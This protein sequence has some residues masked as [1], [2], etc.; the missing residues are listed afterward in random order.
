MSIN[1]PPLSRLRCQGIRDGK[2][3]SATEPV[4]GT[5]RHPWRCAAC[6]VPLYDGLTAEQ[7][8][9]RY[10]K[11]QRGEAERWAIKWRQGYFR[12]HEAAVYAVKFCAGTGMTYIVVPL[13]LAACQLAAACDLWSV[14]LKAKVQAS[15]K[16]KLTIMVDYED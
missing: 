14:Q 12:D 1:G 15:T 13:R 9:E 6:S 11:I 16:P 8:L 4:D 7:C 5:I 10:I 2:Q 3:C